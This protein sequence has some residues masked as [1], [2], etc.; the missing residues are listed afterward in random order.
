MAL[1]DM[2]RA[3]RIAVAVSVKRKRDLRV[4]G[5]TTH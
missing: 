2:V 5:G 3:I 1:D 4:P